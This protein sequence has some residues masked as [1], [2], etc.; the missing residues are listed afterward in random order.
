[1]SWNPEIRADLEWWLDRNRLVLGIDL[2]QVSPQLDFWSDASDV[3]WGAHL[4]EVVVS[5]RW[6]PEKLEFSK[7]AR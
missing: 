7:N 5:G 2:E 4:G 6:A 3:G 1:M